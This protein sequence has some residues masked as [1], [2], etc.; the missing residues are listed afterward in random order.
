MSTCVCCFHPSD[1]SVFAVGHRVF[2][3]SQCSLEWAACVLWIVRCRHHVPP[4]WFGSVFCMILMRITLLY[5][6][7]AFSLMRPFHNLRPMFVMFAWVFFIF[8]YIYI[9]SLFSGVSF[10]MRS[11][12]SACENQWLCVTFTHTLLQSNAKLKL[13]RSLAICEEPSPSTI[14]TQLPQDHQVNIR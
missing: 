7:L 3:Q 8:I 10:A 9:W 1:G 13:V 5:D 2:V 12:T 14:T 6:L 4:S 11:C